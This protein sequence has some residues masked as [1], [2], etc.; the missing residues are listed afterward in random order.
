MLLHRKGHTTRHK[1]TANSLKR[2]DV[3]QSNWSVDVCALFFVYISITKIFL[4]VRRRKVNDSHR[5]Y[6]ESLPHSRWKWWWWWWFCLII[7]I[8]YVRPIIIFGEIWNECT[9]IDCHLCAKWTIKISVNYFMAILSSLTQRFIFAV[10]S[11]NDIN[12]M[13]CF[14][15]NVVATLFSSG[16]LTK[17]WMES[18][19]NYITNTHTHDA[20][21]NGPLCQ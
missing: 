8:Q 6:L 5:M 16:Y 3:G 4:V 13:R 10:F 17:Y 11:K 12:C 18:T 19:G 9:N 2:R 1:K 21:A 7:V 15:D 14:A 20:I